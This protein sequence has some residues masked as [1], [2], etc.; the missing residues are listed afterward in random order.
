[1][2]NKATFQLS[3]RKLLT[4]MA[5]KR[6][7]ENPIV[8]SSGA[9]A[10]PARRKSASPKRTPHIAVPVEASNTPEIEPSVVPA[11]P[12]AEILSPVSPAPSSYAA[13]AYEDIARLAY[14]YWEARGCQGGSPEQDWLRAEQELSAK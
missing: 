5:R 6:I 8:V 10:A 13:P 9:A 7:S 4:P 3:E 11:E 12:V 2:R 1:M 14:T